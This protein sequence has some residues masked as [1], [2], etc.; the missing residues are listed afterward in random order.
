MRG[1]ATEVVIDAPLSFVETL[2]DLRDTPGTERAELQLTRSGAATIATL[3]DTVSTPWYLGGSATARLA[4]SRAHTELQRFLTGFK[5]DTEAAWFES[6][7]Q[8]EGLQR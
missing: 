7:N 1:I 3:L 6:R 4:A 5:N 8:R 2:I